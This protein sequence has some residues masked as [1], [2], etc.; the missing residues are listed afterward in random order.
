VESHL[1]V[2]APG[3]LRAVRFDESTASLWYLGLSYPGAS[4]STPT[5]QIRRIILGP[6]G[7]LIVEW[8]DGDVEFD[9]VWDNRGSLV[10]S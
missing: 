6:G 10:Y 9:N 1:P 5:W 4:T 8:A 2:R 7:D 3:A